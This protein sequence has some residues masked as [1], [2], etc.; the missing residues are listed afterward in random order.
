MGVAV[1]IELARA[2]YAQTR[3]ERSGPVVGPAVDDAAVV[4]G[5]VGADLGLL[6]EHCDR[7]VGPA[8]EC[9][10]GDGQAED[11]GADDGEVVLAAEE[12][13]SRGSAHGARLPPLD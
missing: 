11:S 5:L 1:L 8:R 2:G 13:R 7:G 9:L 4:A 3:L 12:V 10:A 6:L